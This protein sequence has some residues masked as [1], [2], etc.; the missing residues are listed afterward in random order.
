[1]EETLC[2]ICGKPIPEGRLKAI[3]GAM[4]CV[5]CSIVQKKKGFRVISSKTTYHELEIVEEEMFKILTA[6]ERKNN[7]AFFTPQNRPTQAEMLSNGSK[8]DSKLFEK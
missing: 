4:T 8:G 6:Y 5:D 7:G 2:M 3:P 1:M